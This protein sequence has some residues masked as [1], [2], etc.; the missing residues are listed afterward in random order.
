MTYT[1]G[2][3]NTKI[4][5]NIYANGIGAIT[6]VSL[7]SV[8]AYVASLF[9]AYTPTAVSNTALSAIA[10]TAYPQVTRLGYAAAGDSPPVVYTPSVSACSLNAGAGDGGSQVPSAD[11]KCWIAN[12]KGEFNPK[13]WGAACDRSTDDTAALTRMLALVVSYTHITIPNSC[14]FKSPLTFPLANVVTIDGGELLYE[15]TATTGNLVTFGTANYAGGC[16]FR[17]WKIRGLRVLTNTL[18]TG[19]YGVVFNE[20]CGLDLEAFVP[21][22]SGQFSGSTWSWNAVWFNGGNTVDWRGESA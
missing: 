4:S 21:G 16:S 19:G 2:G 11:G 6:A 14:V 17:G 18:M 15:G 1:P 22:G 20:A 5:S 8:L 12:L 9:L 10:S 13:V 7:A 3:L